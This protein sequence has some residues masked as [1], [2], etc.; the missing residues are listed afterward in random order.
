V[1]RCWACCSCNKE[2][3]ADQIG[4]NRAI[5]DAQFE[6][7]V[8]KF[9]RRVAG[10]DH[11]AIAAAKKLINERTGFPTAAQQ[12]ESFNSFVADVGQGA[13]SARLKA[14]AAAGMQTNLNFEINFGKEE[15]KFVGNG[16]WKV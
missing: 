11:F 5:P 9:A 15:L 4:I 3:R 12:Q 1:P 16:P 7:F 8:D 13:V 14:M 10:W 6:E 2:R